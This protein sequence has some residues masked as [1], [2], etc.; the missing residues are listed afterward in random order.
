[1][2]I[3]YIL[4][5]LLLARTDPKIIRLKAHCSRCDVRKTFDVTPEITHKN[6]T[7]ITLSWG[8]TQFTL[9]PTRFRCLLMT[10]LIS[11][12]LAGS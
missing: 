1:M 9:N 2:R 10:S 12:S 11:G 6:P 3:Y 4:R 8:L 7:F 5:L